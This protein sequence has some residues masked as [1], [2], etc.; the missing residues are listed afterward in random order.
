MANVHVSIELNNGNIVR[1]NIAVKARKIKAVWNQARKF[2]DQVV[3]EI[4][5]ASGVYISIVKRE[6]IEIDFGG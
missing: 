4:E 6:E 2:R 1:A 5:N 3:A